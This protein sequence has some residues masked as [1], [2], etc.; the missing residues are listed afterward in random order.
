[1]AANPILIDL[2]KDEA[3][4]DFCS[5]S[6]ELCFNYAWH[7]QVVKTGYDG[8]P[9]VTIEVSNDNVNWDKFHTSSTNYALV[10]DSVTFKRSVSPFK[11]IRI[12]VAS[13]GVTTGTINAK[14]NIKPI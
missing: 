7:L 4:A 1:M 2:I 8:N 10:N 6:Q 9:L 14:I 5:V 11:Y 13:N 3:I 12:C